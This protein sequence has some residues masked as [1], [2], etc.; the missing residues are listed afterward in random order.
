MRTYIALFRGINVGGKNILPMK[1]LVSILAGDGLENVKT[2]IQSG[3]VVFQ[4]NELDRIALSASMSG[5]IESNVGIAPKVILKTLEEVESA[6]ERNPFPEAEDFPKTLHLA[7]LESVPTI[8]DLTSM[9]QIRTISERFEL[10]DDVF[11]LHAPDGIGR[12]K[13]ATKSEK[14]IGVEATMRNWRTVT[15]MLELARQMP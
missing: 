15:K 9:E 4:T 10:I 14:L 13:L 8:P 3:N 2:Y 5:V 12:S 1:T 6:A 11:Y 7:F